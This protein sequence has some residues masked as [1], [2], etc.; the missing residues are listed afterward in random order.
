MKPLVQRTNTV[1]TKNINHKQQIATDQ[2]G[3]FPFTSNKGNKYI[4]VLY[5]YV[6]NFIL[7]CPMN[8][9]ADSEFIR[10]L[11]DLHEHLLTRGIKPAYMRMYN[12]A[13]PAFQGELKAKNIDFQ[14]APPRN[15][16]PQCSGTGNQHIQ[17]SL[18]R[19]ALL[20]RPGFPHE[21]L[22]PPGRTGGDH[23]Q[24]TSPIKTEPQAI[25]IFPT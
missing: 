6:R 20:N 15:A 7:I 1:F 11:T 10:V 19:R 9:R 8:S 16:S 14:L 21:K 2:T 4:F 17:G 22:V 24:L 3:K 13:S 25:G 12:E 18:C 5:G 23:N